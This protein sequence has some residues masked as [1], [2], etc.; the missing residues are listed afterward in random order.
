MGAS[1]TLSGVPLRLAILVALAA[2]GLAATSCG[3]DE[4]PTTGALPKVVVALDFTPNP[5]HAPIYE[6][7]ENGRD[8]SHGV[9]LDVKVPGAGP[10]SVKLVASGKVD[11][12]VLDI[13]DLALARER[14]IDLVG[15]GALVGRPLAALVTQPEIR[16]PRDLAGK[17]VGVSG[18]PS[19]PAFLKAVIQH[20]GGDYH[21]VKQVTVGFNAVGV[22][23][24]HKV[25]AVPAFWNAEGVAL[26]ERGLDVNEFRIEDYG[27][28]RYPEVILMTSRRTLEQHRDRLERALAAIDDGL[29]DTLAD[30]DAATRVIARVAE[31]RNDGL[32]RAELDAVKSAFAPGLHL[33]RPTL[34]RWA[35][36]DARIG[37]VDQR[38]DVTSAFDFTLRR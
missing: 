34:E 18:L 32:V 5:V 22:L 36:F 19:D 23:L 26:R 8:R 6:A 3:G 28:P 2:A 27:A 30:P 24:S 38:P 1:L 9:R 16:R 4:A 29:N 11:L 13:Q 21:A 20:D 12:G 35:D 17:R 10:D 31:A 37:I 15:I 33:D 25:A 14:H 7:I